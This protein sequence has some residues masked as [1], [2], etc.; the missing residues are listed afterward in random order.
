MALSFHFQNQGIWEGDVFLKINQSF[1]IIVVPVQKS[2]DIKVASSFH[3]QNQEI[4][5]GN[6]VCLRKQA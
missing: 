2:G 1:C 3:F 6:D 5:E 4:L